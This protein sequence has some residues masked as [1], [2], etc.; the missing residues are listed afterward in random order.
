[1]RQTGKEEK[2]NNISK[3]SHGEIML[4]TYFTI[5]KQN[6]KGLTSQ[7]QRQGC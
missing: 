1:M 6:A 2:E 4:K 7:S 3:K 5:L